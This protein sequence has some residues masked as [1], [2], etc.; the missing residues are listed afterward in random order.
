[1]E[2]NHEFDVAVPPA[3]AWTVLTDLERIA[4]CLPGANLQEVEGD[5]YRGTVKVKVGPITAQYKG[6]ASFGELDEA[7]GRA[8]LLATGR[9]TKGQG[10]ASATIT[11]D[12][13]AVDGGTH[14]S[15]RTD[16]K[17]SGKVAQFGRGAIAD[18]SSKLM[19]QFVER[20]EGTVLVQGGAAA[21]E[22]TPATATAPTAGTE[23]EAVVAGS[24][25]RRIDGP[26][27]EP[28]DLLATAGA[29][30]A[31]RGAAAAAVLAVVLGIVVIFLRRRRGASRR[32]CE[33]RSE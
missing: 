25:P 8:V 21:V 15:L 28:I 18:V 27:A 23:P 12:L 30:R 1:M 33:L 32:C 7:S 17:I 6:T 2:L 13:T 20:L 14:V 4:P 19:A 26:E 22:P 9:D 16:L 29:T 3:E 5:E 31:A 11:A 24:G 10:N